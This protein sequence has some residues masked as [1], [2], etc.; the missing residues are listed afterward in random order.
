M[1]TTSYKHSHPS[2]PNLA[3]AHRE[4]RR[5]LE[6]IWCSLQLKVSRVEASRRRHP[7][8]QLHE[9]GHDFETLQT[10]QTFFEHCDKT[11]P[12]HRLKVL[13]R[14][15]PRL[16]RRDVRSTSQMVYPSHQHGFHAR[17]CCP[18]TSAFARARHQSLLSANAP[19]AFLWQHWAP[20]NRLQRDAMLAR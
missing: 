15:S 2:H 13:W 9:C 5:W 16:S 18:R 3:T 7:A 10:H 14:R 11:N 20:N 6:N 8:R 4:F 17:Q 1:A 19:H 12:S